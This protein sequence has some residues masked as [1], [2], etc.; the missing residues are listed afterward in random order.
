MNPR[1][2]L[3]FLTFFLVWAVACDASLRLESPSSPPDFKTPVVFTAPISQPTFN[4]PE[5]R[6]EALVVKVVDGDTI[7]VRVAGSE[8]RVRYIGMNT[9][10]TVHPTLGEEPYGREA[11]ARNKAL[12]SG[13][14]VYLEKDV[15]ETDQYGRLL[16]YV[17]LG[18][19]SMVNATLVAEG[20]AQVATYPPD[21]RYVD[22]FLGLQEEARGKGLGL[23]GEQALVG[24]QPC[25]AAY[26]GVCIPPPPPDLDCGEIGLSNFQALPPDPHRFDRDKDGV[27][28][29]R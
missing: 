13:E 15:S 18:D 20:Y 8:H 28:C 19:G 23:W 22:L 24:G 16:R 3:C 25:D 12:V 11:S 27:G 17:W 14:R 29:E 5:D 10:E 2:V 6:V 4:Q 26:P 7:D 21:V 1:V 9:P